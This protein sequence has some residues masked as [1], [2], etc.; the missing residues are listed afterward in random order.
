MTEGVFTQVRVDSDGE[1]LPIVQAHHVAGDRDEL[2][3]NSEEIE[4]NRALKRPGPPFPTVDRGAES[5]PL[6]FARVVKT[7]AM[8][9]GST[10]WCLCQNTV[11]SIVAAW[12]P[13]E[14]ARAMFAAPSC[15]ICGG[16]PSSSSDR[17]RA[18]IRQTVIFWPST[19]IRYPEFGLP[20]SRYRRT[21]TT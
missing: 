9:D 7:V 13:L 3:A 1:P 19:L 11:C 20:P 16:S 17:N 4:P 18:H 10:A 15:V 5:D 8:A 12:L 14:S 2:A 21:E 6:T